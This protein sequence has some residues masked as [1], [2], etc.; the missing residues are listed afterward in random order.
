M[1]LKQNSI[2]DN[3]LNEQE[4]SDLIHYRDTEQYHGDYFDFIDDIHSRFLST[5]ADSFGEKMYVDNSIVRRYGTMVRKNGMKWHQDDVNYDN[6]ILTQRKF[7][8]SI[9]LNRNF[10]GGQ[11]R[12]KIDGEDGDVTNVSPVPGQLVLIRSNIFHGVSD[13]IA[14]TRYCCLLWAR[15]DYD[16]DARQ[17]HLTFGPYD[18]PMHKR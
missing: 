14:G 5:I 4:C 11:F 16:G 13:I 1:N 15:P 3:F 2:H 6:K 17:N 18:D 8:G 9:V 7:T 10:V 12:F